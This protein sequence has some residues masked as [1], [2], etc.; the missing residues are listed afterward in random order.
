MRWRRRIIAAEKALTVLRECSGS[1]AKID[2]DLIG[3]HS[4]GSAI[5]PDGRGTRDANVH[6]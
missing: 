6:E 2:Y 3:A 4:F 5:Q 1:V